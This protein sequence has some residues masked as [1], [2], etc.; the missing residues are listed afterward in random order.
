MIRGIC[1]KI[2][3]RLPESARVGQDRQLGRRLDADSGT[4]RAHILSDLARQRCHVDRLGTQRE[5][6][7]VQPC[8]VQELGNQPT[9]TLELFEQLRGIA[10][11]RRMILARRSATQDLQARLEGGEMVAQI[12]R[13]HGHQV[14]RHHAPAAIERR[15]G[16]LLGQLGAMHHAAHPAADGLQETQ[17]SV[18]K[19]VRLQ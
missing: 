19:E 12:M 16:G 2:L 5:Q 15:R 13:E 9:E 18:R 6:P 1:D 17:I 7:L 3:E 10:Q 4:R 14:L 8:D 11:I